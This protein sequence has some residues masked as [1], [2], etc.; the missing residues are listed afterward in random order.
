M[1]SFVADTN[2]IVSGYH[3]GGIRGQIVD[4]A[5]AGEIDMVISEPIIIEV[6]RVLVEKFRWPGQAARDL[7]DVIFRYAKKVQPTA[8][9]DAVKDD[10]SDNRIIECALAGEVDYIVTGDKHLLRL[11]LFEGIHIVKPSNFIKLV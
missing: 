10:P 5:A 3:F 1:V 2:I 9:I 4:R 8:A 7:E 11:R 6:R